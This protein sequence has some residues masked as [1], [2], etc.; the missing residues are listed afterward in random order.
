MKREAFIKLCGETLY[1]VSAATN[2]NQIAARGLM[3]AAALAAQ[4]DIEPADIAL[5]KHRIIID[6]TA[7]LNHQLPLLKGR[8]R[9]ASFLEGHSLKT[10]AMQLDQR[11]FLGTAT[12]LDALKGSFELPTTVF[13]LDSGLVFDAFV[14][15]LYLSPINSGNADRLPALRGDWIYVPARSSVQDFRTNRQK[16]GL[17]KNRDTVREISLTCAIPPEVLKSL[18][19]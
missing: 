7:T 5:R 1:H 11:V 18:R 9:T 8:A 12:K 16:R 6:G 3:S 13:A 2:E 15:D 4:A 19:V 10:W 14:D 17:V